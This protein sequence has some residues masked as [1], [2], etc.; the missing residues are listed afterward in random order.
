MGSDVCSWLELVSAD[1]PEPDS[2]ISATTNTGFL[3]ANSMSWESKLAKK[4]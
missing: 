4:R 2:Q 3:A 1:L